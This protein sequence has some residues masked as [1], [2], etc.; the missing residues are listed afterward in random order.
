[1]SDTKTDHEERTPEPP[2]KEERLQTI[3]EKLQASLK[4]SQDQCRTAT[5]SLGQTSQALNIC[6][7]Q[8]QQYLGNISVLTSQRN[9]FLDE[10]T[11][12]GVNLFTAKEDHSTQLAEANKRVVST[13]ETAQ[14]SAAA[15]DQQERSLNEVREKFGIT[16]HAR[17]QAEAKSQKAQDLLAEMEEAFEWYYTRARKNTAEKFLKETGRILSLEVIH[18]AF[19]HEDSSKV[20]SDSLLTVLVRMS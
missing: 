10:L 12:T 20:T 5:E 14:H 11:D 13:G 17:K 16:Q 1:M 15:F 6:R 3:I 2:T 4:A 9:A 8:N 7:L 19:C 18:L